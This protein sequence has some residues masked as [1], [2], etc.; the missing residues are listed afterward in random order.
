MN[1]M[2]TTRARIST[3]LGVAKAAN[4]ISQRRSHPPTPGTARRAGEDLGDPRGFTIGGIGLRRKDPGRP[5]PRSGI[6]RSR[7]GTPG[8]GEGVLQ[9][10]GLAHGEIPLKVAQS[11]LFGPVRRQLIPSLPGDRFPPRK[12][13][14]PEMLFELG[15]GPVEPR[16]HGPGRTAEDAAD[17]DIGKPFEIAEDDDVAHLGGEPRQGDPQDRPAQVRIPAG[18]AVDLIPAAED[19]LERHGRDAAPSMVAPALIAGDPVDPR[20]QAR[21]EAEA[22]QAPESLEKDR[23]KD[24][25]RLADVA[26]GID[27]ESP[28]GVAIGLVELP[29]GV[30]V[31]GPDGQ[32]Q[33]A[34]AVDHRR[35][36][37]RPCAGTRIAVG[38]KLVSS[39]GT[40][41]RAG[42]R[43]QGCEIA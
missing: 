10:F 27:D 25:L 32:G 19:G 18:P 5:R 21:A 26:D 41:S 35:R 43:C 2:R 3:A 1:S 11:R 15:Q 34:V 4:R 29:E 31:A 40:I 33:P 9:A 37:A 39:R 36:E 38:F 12:A 17:L 6:G 13:E 28:D 14:R 7:P 24:V 8:N 22:V 42:E 30:F 16:S 20:H 23:L